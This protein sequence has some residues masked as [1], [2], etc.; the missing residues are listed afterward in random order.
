VKITVQIDGDEYGDVEL[1]KEVRGPF[2]MG[3]V[4]LD[5]RNE[6]GEVLKDLAGQA[7]L[8]LNVNVK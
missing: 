8:W 7:Q 4:H 5:R 1:S 2:R 3:H 6:A